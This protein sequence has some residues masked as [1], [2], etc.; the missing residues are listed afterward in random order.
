MTSLNSTMEI[1]AIHQSQNSQEIEDELMADIQEAL[2]PSAKAPDDVTIVVADQKFKSLDDRI[3]QLEFSELQ[4]RIN[5]VCARELSFGSS[6]MTASAVT[7]K[8]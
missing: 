7:Y 5:D 1:L 4:E 8:V 6:G 3:V 2:T